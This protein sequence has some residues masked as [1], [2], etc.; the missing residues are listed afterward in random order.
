M[1]D[2]ALSPCLLD[3]K[4]VSIDYVPDKKTRLEAVQDVSFSLHE[5]EKLGIVGESGCGKTTLILSLLRLLPIAGR[6]TNGEVL[7]HEK[8]LLSLSE[9]EF[10][11]VRWKEIAIVFQGAMNALNP[12][13]TVGDQISEAITCHAGKHTPEE[14]LNKR[15]EDLLEMVGIARNRRHQYPFQFSGGMRQRAMIAMALAC[16][17]SILIADEPTTALD[18]M[19]QAQILELL[20]KLS[21]QLGQSLILVTHDLGVVAEICDRVL[22][23]YGGIV[24]EYGDVDTIYNHPR[25]PYTQLLIKAFPN[26]A[27][28]TTSLVSIAG[29]PPRLD[30]LPPGCRFAPRCPFAFDRCH[31]EKPPLYRVSKFHQASCFLVEKPA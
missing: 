28:P 2:P 26:L 17:P 13:K 27:N 7:Y 23:M 6:I 11:D 29:Y 12:V 14:V 10:N 1:V 21:A 19:I 22:V 20:E 25:H 31:H 8:D 5:G 4:N 15:V 18:V 9:K 16:S 24:A 3:V 30:Q